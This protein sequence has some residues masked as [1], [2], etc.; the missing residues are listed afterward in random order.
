MAYIVERTDIVIDTARAVAS[1]TNGDAMIDA[2]LAGIGIA[3]TPAFYARQGLAEGR[4]TQLMPGLDA[5]GPP[6]QL[7][8]P[9]RRQIPRRVRVLMDY[10]AD[11]IT[12]GLGDVYRATTDAQT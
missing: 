3:Q 8:Y 9:C 11:A 5:P 4:L 10:I 1:F 7:V 12:H 6:I 2:A